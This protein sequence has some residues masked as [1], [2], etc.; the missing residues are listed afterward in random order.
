MNLSFAEPLLTA[1]DEVALARAVEAGTLATALLEGVSVPVSV[2][3]T[4]AELE[5]VAAAGRAARERFLL[6]NGRLVMAEARRVSVRLSLPVDELFQEG[7]LGLSEAVDRFDHTRGARFAAVAVPWIRARLSVQART[8]CGR[9]HAP[10]HAVRR[11]GS[12]VLATVSLGPMHEQHAAVPGPEEVLLTEA[13]DSL[14]ASLLDGV[15][16][17]E[18]AVLIRRYGPEE[19]TLAEIAE[20]LGVSLSTVRRVLE[21]GLHRLRTRA[22]LRAA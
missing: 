8:R 9:V 15:T 22:R 4:H 6:A 21:R 1:A 5:A 18:R 7:W 10:A 17:L 13:D 20:D 16:A 11:H 12:E 19:L 2:E 14:L 3:A